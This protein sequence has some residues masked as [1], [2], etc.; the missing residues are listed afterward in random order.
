MSIL[1]HEI[2]VFLADIGYLSNY[3][4]TIKQVWAKKNLE[5]ISTF[6]GWR[7]NLVTDK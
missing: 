6:E 4:A 2:T 5:N 7:L 1:N 3:Y